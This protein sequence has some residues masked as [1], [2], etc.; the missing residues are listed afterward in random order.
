MPGGCHHNTKCHARYEVTDRFLNLVNRSLSVTQFR[1]RA[2]NVRLLDDHPFCVFGFIYMVHYVTEPVQI[3]S[4]N[5]VIA[6][7]F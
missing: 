3:E 5:V 4:G 6:L 1:L 7:P 2:S